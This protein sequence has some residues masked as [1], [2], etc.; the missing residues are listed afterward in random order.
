[1]CSS[2]SAHCCSTVQPAGADEATVLLKD[3]GVKVDPNVVVGI[4]CE[5]ITV[6]GIGG[7][8]CPEQLV[9]CEQT[10]LNGLVNIDCTPVSD[11]ALFG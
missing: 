7:N 1:M 10:N 5:P 2:G 3:L 11:G 9:C 4:S 8:S 6:L